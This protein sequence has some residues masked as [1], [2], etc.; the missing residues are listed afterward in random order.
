MK[1]RNT[2]VAAL[3]V[4]GLVVACSDSFSK[5][6][7][8]SGDFN[9]VNNGTNSGGPNPGND[10]TSGIPVEDEYEFE[11]ARPAVVG[12]QVFVA[13]ETA[14][15]VAVIDS[16]T[17]GIRT[18]PVGFGPTIVA[19]PSLEADAASVFVLN[20]GAST[21]SAIDPE[22]L[23]PAT[24]PV[25]RG[26]NSLRA[27][28][29]GR[30]AVAWFD[31]ELAQS[32]TAIGDLSAVSVVNAAGEAFQIAV[33]YRVERVDFADDGNVALV[34]T[35]DGISSIDLESVDGDGLEPP[36][37]VLPQDLQQFDR[38]DR[39][40]LVDAAGRWA[41]ARIVSVR[42]LVLTDLAS[43]E[44]WVAGT[45]ET[46]TDID[47][48][49]AGDDLKLLA[50]LPTLD[51]ALVADLPEG[52][53]NLAAVM[54][55]VD[56]PDPDPDMGVADMGASDMGA[57][58]A[59][60]MDAADMRGDMADSGAPD[61][62]D[63]GSPDAGDLPDDGT[64]DGGTD[65]G[66]WATVDGL[67]ILDLEQDGLGAAEV[68]N[69]GSIALIFTTRAEEKAGILLTLDSLEQRTIAFE[70][71]IRGAVS[72]D[73]GETFVVFHTRV[74]GQVPVGATPG[75]PE[76]VANKWGISIV[77]VASGATRL[78][79]TE[80]EPA[81]AALWSGDGIER[82]YMTFEGPQSQATAEKSHR[83]VLRVDL[84]TFSTETF[85]VP[86]LPDSIGTVPEAGRIYID[87]IHPQGRLTFVEVATDERQ[88]VT[89]YQLNAGID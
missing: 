67:R 16:R 85:R 61:G 56:P 84:E 70:K 55:V 10:G 62:G 33:G 53:V 35:D 1:P 63:A 58:D 42:A 77:D 79:L 83:D 43:G 76:F 9:N 73:E 13:N 78:V 14:N 30:F 20:E 48:V 50:M 57:S 68:S 81:D 38:S 82:L 3:A 6:N 75:D 80:Q 46:P 49:G 40:V 15:T 45:A 88:T 66:A 47:L 31:E 11:F 12:T 32:G 2:I 27:S 52:L 64:L 19:G 86:S 71:G 18:V 51:Q 74:P 25:L 24:A 17:L 5:S 65:P 23:E 44:Q 39:E 41:V 8:G 22:S 26:A 60:D 87:Q 4:A 29:D 54:P 34:V 89:G 36:V 7:N 59:G 72:D 28:P 21:V 69:D 37:A